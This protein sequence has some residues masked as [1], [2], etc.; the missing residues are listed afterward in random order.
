MK[1]VSFHDD[2]EAE[3]IEAARYYEAKSTGLGAALVVEVAEA[4]EELRENPES[5]QLVATEVRRRVLRRF[6]Y[7]LL[8]VVEPDRI[9]VLAV[10]HNRRR[11]GYW[12]RR[13]R[14]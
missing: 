4:A 1:P 8:Y 11:P 2:A 13:R 10:S 9:R 12:S 7:S 5:W 6:P 3:L 14:A